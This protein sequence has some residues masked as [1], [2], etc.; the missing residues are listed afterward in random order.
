MFNGLSAFPLTPMNEE[1]IKEK[2]YVNLIQRLVDA[3]VDSIGALGSTGNYAY[4]NR[5]ERFRTL[6]LAVE[7]AN[8]IPV[9]GSISAIRT[10][11][12]L[13]LA[14]DA[15]KAGVSAFLLAP[16]SYQVLSHDEVY[17]LFRTRSSQSPD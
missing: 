7:S 5:Q 14:E 17:S 9:M 10:L 13:L 16:V 3:G 12:V 1:G 6:K 2:E 4:L 11:D 8:G 15:Q